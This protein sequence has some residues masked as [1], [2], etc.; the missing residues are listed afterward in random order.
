[1]ESCIELLVSFVD[2]TN[3]VA[4]RTHTDSPSDSSNKDKLGTRGHVPSPRQNYCAGS[5]QA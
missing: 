5:Y 2:L 3:F 4:L 1:M